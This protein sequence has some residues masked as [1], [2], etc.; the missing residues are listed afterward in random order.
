MVNSFGSPVAILRPLTV[1][2]SRSARGETQPILIFMSSAVRSPIM[3]ENSLRTYLTISSSNLLPPH[4][5]DSETTMSFKHITAM[6]TVPPPM[7]ITIIPRG[8]PMSS[9]APSAAAIGSSI[10]SIFFAPAFVTACLTARS[11]T[12][13]ILDGT[14]TTAFGGKIEFPFAFRIKY[15]SICSVLS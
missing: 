5:T 10:S 1:I 15:R 14:H 9:P 8:L 3:Q 12:S 7:S 11:S 13:F 2:V 4:F 6:S